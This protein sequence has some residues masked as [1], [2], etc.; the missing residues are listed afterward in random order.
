MYYSFQA[1]HDD[2]FYLPEEHPDWQMI[3]SRFSFIEF[4][5][6][7]RVVQSYKKFYEYVATGNAFMSKSMVHDSKLKQYIYG[8]L[9][10]SYY[11]FFKSKRLE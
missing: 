2:L 1:P 11:F 3:K 5:D 4:A 6:D 7:H 10:A 9:Y 8:S